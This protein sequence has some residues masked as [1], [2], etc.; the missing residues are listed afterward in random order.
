LTKLKAYWK[1]ITTSWSLSSNN[2]LPSLAEEV[3]SLEEESWLELDL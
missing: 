2:T 3:H 1:N